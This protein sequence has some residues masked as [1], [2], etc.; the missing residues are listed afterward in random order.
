MS[1]LLG[2]AALAQTPEEILAGLANG[3]GV[4]GALTAD[5]WRVI[6]LQPGYGSY[7]ETGAWVRFHFTGWIYDP[8]AKDGKGERFDG[9]RDRKEPIVFQLGRGRVIMGWEMGLLGMQAGGKRLLVV[10]PQLG[11]GDKGAGERN[12]AK[13]VPPNAT[14]VF[15]VELIDFLPPLKP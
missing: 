7:T 2:A 11:F 4:S 8:A 15:E 6:D 12:G 9:S 3:K 14:L 5:G 13:A 1:L 10:P